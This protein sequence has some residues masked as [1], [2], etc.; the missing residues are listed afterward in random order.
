MKIALA[1]IVKGSDEEAKVLNECLKYSRGFFS[2]T[3]ITITHKTGEARNK[4][5]ERVIESWQGEPKNIYISDFEWCNDFSKARNFNF[6]QVPKA[7]DYIM[8]CDADDGFRGLELLQDVLNNNRDI[9]AFSMNYLYFF[10]EYKQPTVVHQKTQI[11]KN[12][13]C[14]EWYGALH[15]DLKKIEIQKENSLKESKDFT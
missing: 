3:Y 8:W 6:S 13:G 2:A 14:L 12:D 4:E 10:D 11:I 15:E 5:V 9:D 7:Y 1:L